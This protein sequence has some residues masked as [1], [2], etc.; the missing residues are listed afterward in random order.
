MYGINRIEECRSNTFSIATN[1]ADYYSQKSCRKL[2]NK[3]Q[4]I[5]SVNQI[6]TLHALDIILYPMLNFLLCD[7]TYFFSQSARSFL[8]KSRALVKCNNTFWLHSREPKHNGWMQLYF[9][10]IKQCNRR[11]CAGR[12]RRYAESNII[13][14]SKTKHGTM[15]RSRYLCLET[16]CL[17]M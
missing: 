10:K 5:F 13:I 9:G 6:F 16:L 3:W 15:H 2:D 4:K 8:G 17:E 12:I 14:F 1:Y 11:I 7:K